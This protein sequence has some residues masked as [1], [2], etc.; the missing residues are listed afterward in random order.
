M[1][2]KIY[3]NYQEFSKRENKEENGVN[4]SFSKDYPKY[5]FHNALRSFNNAV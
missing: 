4:E 1:K 2:T 3:K 5:I